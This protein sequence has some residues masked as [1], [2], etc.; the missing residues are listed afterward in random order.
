LHDQKEKLQVENASRDEL[1]TRIAS[2]SAFL[3][4]QPVIFIEYGDQPVSRLIEKVTI[5][6]EKFT[7]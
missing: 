1:K 3:K 4:K 2:I 5:I 6:E 7:M